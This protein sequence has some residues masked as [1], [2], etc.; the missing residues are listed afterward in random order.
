M[1]FISK[2]ECC[3]LAA[4]SREPRPISLA[5][6]SNTRKHLVWPPFFWKDSF[7]LSLL[8][9]SVLVDELDAYRTW[10]TISQS[11][12]GVARA[13]SDFTRSRI[14]LMESLCLTAFFSGKVKS[15]LLYWMNQFS[16]RVRCVSN[17]I[18]NLAI[19]PRCRA[20]RVRFHSQSF[21]CH[22]ITLFDRF[23]FWKGY[24]LL[25]LLNESV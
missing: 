12:R 11:C 7:L 3:Y 9:E 17:V 14:T 25:S 18:N 6:V 10:T 13:A 1:L 5:V 21:N 24:F 15:Y 20:T 22:R 19:L 23:F 16:R 2:Q 4:V 8:N